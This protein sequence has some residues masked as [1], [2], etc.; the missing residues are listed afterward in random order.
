MGGKPL[1]LI[2]QMASTAIAG[3]TTKPAVHAVIL[4]RMNQRK[5]MR[6][7][8]R[9]ELM[10]ALRDA[11]GLDPFALEREVLDALPEDFVFR[12]EMLWLRVYG[13]RQPGV[14]NPVASARRVTRVSTNQTETR[15]PAKPRTGPMIPG[16]VGNEAALLFK[17]RLDRKLRTL[18]RE[19]RA[20]LDRDTVKAGVRRCTKCR[21]YAEDTWVYC[22]WDGSPTEEAV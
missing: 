22:P 8:L 15:G 7:E 14:D 17:Q 16:V 12:Y 11:G 2:G 10:R 18:A 21:R 6:E 4:P 3:T 13:R 9:A 1:V 5:K 19:M 20:W